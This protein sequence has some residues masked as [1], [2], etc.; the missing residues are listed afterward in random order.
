MSD[1]IKEEMNKMVAEARRI[2]EHGELSWEEIDVKDDP[3]KAFATKAYKGHGEGW[4]FTI[5]SFD[6]EPQG[7]PPGSRGYDGAAVHKG[8]ILHLPRDVAE[9]GLK[10]AEKAVEAK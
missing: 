1:H 2:L 8:T 7:F 9:L 5:V 3:A 6:I 4:V 10:K